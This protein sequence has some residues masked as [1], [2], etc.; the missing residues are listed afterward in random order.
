M[1]EKEDKEKVMKEGIMAVG[2]I[3]AV[4][5]NELNKEIDKVENKESAEIQKGLLGMVGALSIGLG[6]KMVYEQVY[7]E[8]IEASKKEKEKAENEEK[9]RIEKRRYCLRCEKCGSEKV[10]LNYNI[11]KGKGK[12]WHD[13]EFGKYYCHDGFGWELDDFDITCAECGSDEIKVEHEEIKEVIK[14][15]VKE[16][17]NV[18]PKP[19]RVLK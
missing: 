8:E 9:A 7:K 4:V 17:K 19:I 10:Y 6:T 12:T 18:K 1:S 11:T 16:L 13:I 5:L 15:D 3:T 14:E 2:M